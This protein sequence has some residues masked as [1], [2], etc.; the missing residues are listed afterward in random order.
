MN[1]FTA[2]L[3][4]RQ[5][6]KIT[7]I[8]GDDYPTRDGTAIRDY[9]HVM[10][11]ADAHVKAA[12]WL[13]RESSNKVTGLEVFNIGTGNGYS[14]LEVINKFIEN[15]F[16][17]K[18]EIAG[19]RDGDVAE[20]YADCTKANNIL[21]CRPKYSFDKMVEDSIFYYWSMLS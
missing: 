5:A 10:D 15:G 18:Y 9:I 7:Y 3:N 11:V 13:E 19:R 21:E 8:F 14:V 6:D 4:N 12:E 2:I 20:V 16:H 1:L 17:I